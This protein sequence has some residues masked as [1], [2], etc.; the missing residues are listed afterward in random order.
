MRHVNIGIDNEPF[1]FCLALK[2]INLLESITSIRNF[3]SMYWTS[4]DDADL[5]SSLTSY[6]LFGNMQISCQLYTLI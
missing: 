2:D 3:Y 5:I 4:L 1:E 6:P